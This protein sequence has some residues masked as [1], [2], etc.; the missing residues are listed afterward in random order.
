MGSGIAAACAAAGCKT[1]MLD[2]SQELADRGKSRM[3]V[4]R[5]P[6]LDDPSAADFDCNRQF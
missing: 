3:L 4:G 6:M 2:V 5:F 1:V